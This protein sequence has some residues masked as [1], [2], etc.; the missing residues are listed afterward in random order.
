VVQ[1]N[2]KDVPIHQLLLE[3]YTACRSKEGDHCI[4]IDQ[5]VSVNGI[6]CSEVSCHRA[7]WLLDEGAEV[8]AIPVDVCSGTEDN[9]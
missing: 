3:G 8:D 6:H 5:Y 2:G 1:V 9:V 4:F 7:I